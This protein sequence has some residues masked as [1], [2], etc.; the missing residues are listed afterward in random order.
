MQVQMNMNCGTP[1][2]ERVLRTRLDRL[3]RSRSTYLTIEARLTQGTLR[4]Q[5]PN[6]RSF[7]RGG[8][9]RMTTSLRVLEGAIWPRRRRRKIVAFR[10]QLFLNLGRQRGVRREGHLI[11]RIERR[12]L[13][14]AGN[15]RFVRNIVERSEEERE[16][17]LDHSDHAGTGEF[18]DDELMTI[19]DQDVSSSVEPLLRGLQCGSQRYSLSGSVRA[20]RPFEWEIL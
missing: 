1:K 8:G 9:I 11:G 20:P 7:S 13:D 3:R 19:T 4:D 14:I 2:V 5:A 10:L 18:S 6:A 17:R 12:S 16:F 15:G